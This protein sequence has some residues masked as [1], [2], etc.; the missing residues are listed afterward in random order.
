MCGHDSDE[1]DDD[2]I[3]GMTVMIRDDAAG[4]GMAADM[5]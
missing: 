4:V 5:G 1:R 2:A 3:A